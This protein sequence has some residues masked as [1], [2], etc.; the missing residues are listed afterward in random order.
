[1]EEAAK[2][3]DFNSSDEPGVAATGYTANPAELGTNPQPPL[4]TPPP[5]PSSPSRQW[6]NQPFLTSQYQR[7]GQFGQIQTATIGEH[8]GNVT[9]KPELNE[10]FC[11]TDTFQGNNSFFQQLS[12]IYDPLAVQEDLFQDEFNKRTF[13]SNPRIQALQ[14]SQKIAFA[15]IMQKMQE[16]RKIQ[17]SANHPSNMAQI[18]SQPDTNDAMVIPQTSENILNHDNIDTMQQ[19][20]PEDVQ[21]TVKYSNE[22]LDCLAS[23]SMTHTSRGDNL[24]NVSMMQNSK[25]KSYDTLA[26]EMRQ[27][28]REKSCDSYSSQSASAKN[29][30]MGCVNVERIVPRGCVN[31]VQDPPQCFE[32][33]TTTHQF[34]SNQIDGQL[35]QKHSEIQNVIQTNDYRQ[36]IRRTNASSNQDPREQQ[37]NSADRSDAV[38]INPDYTLKFNNEEKKL[39]LNPRENESFLVLTPDTT[40]TNTPPIQQTGEEIDHIIRRARAEADASQNP[41]RAV[42]KRPLSRS[43]ILE[44][45]LQKKDTTSAS[46]TTA[47][48]HHNPSPSSWQSN[49]IFEHNVNREEPNSNPLHFTY[50]PSTRGPPFFQQSDQ[51]QSFSK[52]PPGFPHEEGKPKPEIKSNEQSQAIHI[53]GVSIRNT[54]EAAL[55]QELETLP[56]NQVDTQ[57]DNSA[58]GYSKPTVPAP[59]MEDFIIQMEHCETTI[60]KLISSSSSKI[61][62]QAIKLVHSFQ[63]DYLNGERIYLEFEPS[64]KYHWI[65]KNYAKVL[66]FVSTQAE[67]AKTLH[68]LVQTKDKLL[69]RSFYQFHQVH[70]IAST[71]YILYSV[72]FNFVWIPLQYKVLLSVVMVQNEGLVDSHHAW[73]KVS[74]DF[75][76]NLLLK[77]GPVSVVRANPKNRKN[78][79][80]TSTSSNTNTQSHQVA[81][82]GI[83]TNLKEL[84]IQSKGGQL[85]PQQLVPNVQDHVEMTDM[86]IEDLTILDEWTEKDASSSTESISEVNEAKSNESKSVTPASPTVKELNETKI[87][88]VYYNKSIIIHNVPLS[89]SFGVLER[90]ILQYGNISN[91]HMPRTPNQDVTVKLETVQQALKVKQALQDKILDGK[92]ISVTHKTSKRISTKSINH[93]SSTDSDSSHSAANKLICQYCDEVFNTTETL[94][95]HTLGVHGVL[96]PQHQPQPRGQRWIANANAICR[97]CNDHFPSE[98]LLNHHSLAVH[99]VLHAPEGQYPQEP[100]IPNQPQPFPQVPTANP[101]SDADYFEMNAL[102]VCPSHTINTWSSNQRGSQ[103]YLVHK[104][105]D[106]EAT[107]RAEIQNGSVVFVTCGNLPEPQVAEGTMVVKNNTLVLSIRN[108]YGVDMTLYPNTIVPGITAHLLPFVREEVK[109]VN[110]AIP[111]PFVAN[112]P[113]WHFHVKRLKYDL[114]IKKKTRATAFRKI[115]RQGDPEHLDIDIV[116]DHRPQIILP[117]PLLATGAKLNQFGESYLQENPYAIRVTPETRSSLV[118]CVQCSD[119][120]YCHCGCSTRKQ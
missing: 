68:H 20:T 82:F 7:A 74:G 40:K 108:S 11:R 111:D 117:K 95:R 100:M 88:D 55:L 22:G 96:Q 47:I 42:R 81:N 43:R 60:R 16:D 70:G 66:Q 89:I 37:S 65:H 110:P 53:S 120:I 5:P 12:D 98:N 48:I 91:M 13:S 86:D 92:V 25:E 24:A 83:G 84:T 33:K 10:N 94:E 90:M 27:D 51:N 18:Q 79:A 99:G 114:W 63:K 28:S 59:I 50:H 56:D 75:N 36:E 85:R 106:S 61:A 19:S 118:L 45:I 2:S 116:T 4:D 21:N 67:P 14:T 71:A 17:E 30:Y 103:F 35:V 104:N 101:I 109:K 119:P 72:I 107:R 80:E 73:Q 46:Q 23:V 113:R 29:E 41:L 112:I 31:I 78:I 62:E 97:F 115:V 1:M 38:Q 102:Y 76:F 77:S 69:S 34:E 8:S 6:P 26:S 93:R 39:Q 44:N 9:R 49:P 3:A 15:K 57:K 54:R 105:K 32:N 58:S 64:F 52:C 87:K